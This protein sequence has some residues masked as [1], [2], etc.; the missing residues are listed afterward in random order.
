MPS[1]KALSLSEMGGKLG[2]GFSPRH[3]G[4]A[5]LRLSNAIA[6]YRDGRDTSGNTVAEY[7]LYCLDGLLKV[8]RPPIVFD[9]PDVE[10]ARSKTE[11]L[12]KGAQC[13]LWQG[14]RLVARIPA[15]D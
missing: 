8:S 15:T 5:R 4:H 10:T 7:K 12:R 2:R 3:W 6:S 13:E 1:G 11:A 9:A 14:L